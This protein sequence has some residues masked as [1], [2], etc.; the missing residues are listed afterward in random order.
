MTIADQKISYLSAQQNT[1][2]DPLQAVARD[3]ADGTGI[4]SKAGKS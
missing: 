3:G 2:N 1:I 4:A